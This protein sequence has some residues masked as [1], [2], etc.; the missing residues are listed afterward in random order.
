MV[1]LFY[2]NTSHIIHIPGKFVPNMIS[3]LSKYVPDQ[4]YKQLMKCQK[5]ITS[6][7]KAATAKLQ[8][9]S[10]TGNSDDSSASTLVEDK[11]GDSTS[12]D[13]SGMD[14]EEAELIVQLNELKHLVGAT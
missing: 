13:P 9:L 4:V 12:V 8:D 5:L 6:Q 1:L 2:Q 7:W 10:K 11:E 14:D 3:C